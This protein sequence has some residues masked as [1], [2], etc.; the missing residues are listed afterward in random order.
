M[1][2]VTEVLEWIR[3]NP[4]RFG[5][6]CMMIIYFGF[7]FFWSNKESAAYQ[8]GF[9][10]GID[11]TYQKITET[12][13]QIRGEDNKIVMTFEEEEEGEKDIEK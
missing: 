2:E 12:L 9:L 5:Y 4:Y 13:L 7:L 10:D 1:A 11:A 8:K 3:A 6:W